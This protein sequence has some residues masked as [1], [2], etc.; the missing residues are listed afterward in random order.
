LSSAEYQVSFCDMTKSED[1]QQ[2][3]QPSTAPVSFP[4]W[5]EVLHSEQLN[6]AL[7]RS[8]EGE[9]FAYLKY[10]KAVRRRASVESVLEYLRHLEGQGRETEAARSALRW[11]FQAAAQ[12]AQSGMDEIEPAP[13]EP[14]QVIRVEQGDHGGPPWEQRMVAALRTRHL[15]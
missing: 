12:Q 7:A 2:Q 10:L 3:Q 13:P 9:I 5:R 6:P 15:Q 8:L 14:V 4:R 1:K 11:F